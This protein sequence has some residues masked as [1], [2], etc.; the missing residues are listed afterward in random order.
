[1]IK[2]AAFS[3]WNI[4]VRLHAVWCIK[5]LVALTHCA[6]KGHCVRFRGIYWQKFNRIFNTSTSA[7]SL[8]CFYCSPECTLALDSAFHIF[9]E[10]HSQCRFSYI[11][12][13]EGEGEARGIHLQFATE[14][15]WV[16]LNSTLDL[17]LY[18]LEK[19]KCLFVFFRIISLPLLF[20]LCVGIRLS[21]AE[22]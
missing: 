1:M 20:A 19:T 12:Y 16:P 9:H 5:L 17:K 13:L 14:S 15:A 2:K 10:F 22:N 7:S 18:W 8:S 4:W 11:Q 3:Y 6:L 21:S